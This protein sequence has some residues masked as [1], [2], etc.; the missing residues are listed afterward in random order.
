MQ[1]TNNVEMKRESVKL[2]STPKAD[3]VRGSTIL[4][5]AEN[6]DETIGDRI[7][8]VK[9]TGTLGAGNLFFFQVKLTIQKVLLEKFIKDL[10]LTQMLP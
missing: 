4:K 9:I 10:G 3:T 1:V 2:E 8:D 7:E 5:S 6:I